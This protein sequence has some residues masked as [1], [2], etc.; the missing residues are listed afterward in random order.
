M[1]V[2]VVT[3]SVG[4]GDRPLTHAFCGFLQAFN[5][6][7]Q[8]MIKAA[9]RDLYEKIEAKL[10]VRLYRGSL[11]CQFEYAISSKLTILEYNPMECFYNSS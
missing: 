7:N 2:K 6:Q 4:Y 11:P 10:V 8:R 3:V 9:L 5:K 1:F